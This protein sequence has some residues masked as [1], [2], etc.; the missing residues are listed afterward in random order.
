[1]QY[2]SGLEG[3]NQGNFIGTGIIGLTFINSPQRK[4]GTTDLHVHKEKLCSD[5]EFTAE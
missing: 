1:L 4:K 5:H 2:S 3:I